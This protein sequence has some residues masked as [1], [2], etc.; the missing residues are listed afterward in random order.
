[1][2]KRI[3]FLILSLGFCFML[4]NDAQAVIKD[5]TY[6]YD[7]S[8]IE[9]QLLNWT[10]AWRQTTR[11]T[12]P[13][14]LDRMEY[15]RTTRKVNIYLSGSAELASEGNLQKG[16]DTIAK[17]FIERFKKIDPEA[18]LLLHITLLDKDNKETI[19]EYKDGLFTNQVTDIDYRWKKTSGGNWRSSEGY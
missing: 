18:E 14:T 4:V 2:R 5:Y 8:Q 15:D 10:S 1:M 16:M 19:I 6:P 13:F 3:M 17:L 7:I 12:D 11:G 9:W